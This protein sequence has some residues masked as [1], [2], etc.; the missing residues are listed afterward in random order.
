MSKTAAP[1]SFWLSAIL[2]IAGVVAASFVDDDGG[3]VVLGGLLGIAL[4]LLYRVRHRMRDMESRLQALE[5]Q[6]AQSALAAEPRAR[7]ATAPA[8]SPAPPLPQAVMPATSVAAPPPPVSSVPPPPQRAVQVE[9]VPRPPPPPAEP[10]WADRA[11][12]AAVAWL[13]RGNPIAR[14]GVVTLFFGGSFLAK[15]AAEHSMFPIELRMAALGAGAL[16]LLGV[17]W[18]LRGKQPLYAQTLQGG[19]IAGFYLT[20]FAATRLYHLLPQ[21]MALG[22][23]VVVALAAAVLAVAQNALALAVIGTGG[24]FLAPILL[25]TGGGSLA[26]L[27][28]YYT[29]LNLGVF[30][31]AWFRAW[32]VLNLVGFVFTFGVAGLFRATAYTAPQQA[33]MDF[34]LWLFF[35]LYVAVSVLFSLRQKP[36]LKGYVSG[37]LVFGLPLAAFSL[38]TSVIGHEGLALAWS[39]L[40]LALFYLVL[41]AVLL[42]T[43][44]DNLRLLVEAFAALGVIFATLAVPLGFDRHTTATAWAVEGAGL[45]W[46][47]TRQQRR[48]ARAFGLLVQ[49]AAGIGYLLS[50]GDYQPAHAVLNGLFLGSTTLALSGLLSGW[51]LFRNR[52]A[53]APHEAYWDSI[54]ML[55]GVAWWL[56]GGLAEIDR[57]AANVELGAAL[58]L[59]AF[60][61]S[62][63][64]WLAGRLSWP[65][66]LRVATAL[67]PLSAVLGLTVAARY[68]HP[69]SQASW[70]GWP[71]LLAAGWWLL[72][73]LDTAA[74]DLLREALPVLHAAAVWLL[75]LLAAWELSWRAEL[76]IGGV[77]RELPWG[78][79][80]ALLLGL[81][82]RARLT[83]AWP[84]A[85]HEETYRLLAAVPLGLL[86]AA[87]T[88]AINLVSDGDPRELPYLPLLNPLDLSV[89]LGLVAQGWYWSS[90]G[91]QRR[92]RLTPD[93]PRILPGAAAAVVFLWLNAALIRALHY[94]AGT[95]LDLEG[96]FRS[97]TVQAALSIFWGLLAFASMTLAARRS[98]RALWLAGA[99][100]M[101]VLLLKLF[102]VDT[103][104]RG[105]LARIV[106][107]LIVGA[108]LLVTGYLSPLPPH[109]P[110]GTQPETDPEP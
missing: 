74:D 51:W 41:A 76:E 4:A 27:F 95:P 26:A 59:A 39:A 92:A 48:L 13:K 6:V 40:G 80:P 101:A 60:T 43:R 45:V 64:G 56:A 30:A 52:Q 109:K 108:L 25:S 89:L 99:G 83:P 62:V 58:A 70:L 8:A 61:A 21:P 55:W 93:D 29:V 12:A 2:V 85:R 103:A 104:G 38:H 10:T 28:T 72:W 54:V 9:H 53:S 81:L 57:Y 98:Q 91:P 102:L 32:R 77:W 96:I 78:V 14:A 16:L 1:A 47:G 36:D 106:S 65:L 37:S 82:S 23:M 35:V 107:F 49:L 100:L 7:P 44:I 11:Y 87:W 22:L 5:Q 18:R 15:Y 20:V 50:R 66:L 33:T 97:I 31:V 110:A 73:R 90:L 3:R 34:F 86:I 84:L 63:L 42:R 88:V 46:L 68:S 105:T 71:L 19:G 75:A 94:A 69:L 24:G 67:L 79:V 17:G